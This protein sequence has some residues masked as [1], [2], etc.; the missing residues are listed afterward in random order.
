[1]A[2]RNRGEERGR[3]ACRED[4]WTRGQRERMKG[5]QSGYGKREREKERR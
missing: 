3:T 4:G 1:M 2:E 5:R